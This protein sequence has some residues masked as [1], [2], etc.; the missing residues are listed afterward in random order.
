DAV[1][2]LAR[3][4]GYNIQVLGDRAALA[5]RKITLDTGETTFWQAFDQLCEKGGLVENSNFNP[6]G[7][8]P[9]V[10]PGLPG[11]PVPPPPPQQLR[12]AQPVQVQPVPLPAPNGPVM[13][14]GVRVRPIVGQLNL[15]DGKRPNWPTSYSGA[16][17]VRA[18]PSLPQVQG[19]MI[20][21]Q[22]EKRAGE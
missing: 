9:Y 13:R 22:A 5:S 17:R 14:P 1:A 10:Q 20:V 4:S 8:G 7:G 3:Q 21:P 15:T 12:P 18:V 16:I 19:R 6:N 2:E 11:Q